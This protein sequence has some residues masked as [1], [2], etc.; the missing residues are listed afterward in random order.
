MDFI[1][2]L[3]KLEGKNVIMVVVDQLTKY[4]HLCYLSHPFSA[5]IVAAIFMDIV[6]NLHANPKIIVSDRDPI[7]Q[8][9]FGMNYFLFWEPN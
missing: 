2:D 5:S 8:E 3:P 1:T 6:Q 7:S 9:N 4:A